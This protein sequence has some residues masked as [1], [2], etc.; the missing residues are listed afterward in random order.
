MI[1]E[2]QKMLDDLP[3]VTPVH[4]PF[5]KVDVHLI[6]S[7]RFILW[8]KVCC[9]IRP[10]K[11]D[12]ILSHFYIQIRYGIKERVIM[13]IEILRVSN[14]ALDTFAGVVN[15]PQGDR[16]LCRLLPRSSPLPRV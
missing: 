12:S 1:E 9:F 7:I 13:T 14:F 2:T 8:V 5:Y 16:R 11:H 6:Q 4:A 15:L 10:W 3:G